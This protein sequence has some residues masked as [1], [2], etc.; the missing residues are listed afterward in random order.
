MAKMKIKSTT[1]LFLVGV[2]LAFAGCSTAYRTGQ[3][4]DDVYSSPAPTQEEYAKIKKTDERRY[5]TYDDA[6][7]EYEDYDD[8][9]LRM[10]VR[11]R[12]RWSDLNDWYYYGD[13]YNFSYYNN[14]AYWNDPWYWN[15][16]WSPVSYWNMWYNPWY[17]GWGW[18]GG[19][20]WGGW[21]GGGWGWNSPWYAGWG[22]WYGGGWGWGGWYDP[23]YNGWYGPGWGW[24]GGWYGGGVI[25]GRRADYG[26]RTNANLGS[27]SGGR[28]NVSVGTG[29]GR[30]TPGYINPTGGT[31]R[32]T[33]GVR[34]N[35]SVST[36]TSN[37][38][39][40]GRS[41]NTGSYNRS[42]NQGQTYNRDVYSAP[43]SNESRPT[44]SPP[45]LHLLILPHLVVV[46]RA[47][48][49]VEAPVVAVAE[50]AEDFS[51]AAYTPDFYYYFKPIKFYT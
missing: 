28:G 42:Y 44:Y 47:V 12:N 24:G 51:T 39:S 11:N 35:A 23:W 29:S 17:S 50:A 15:N 25:V 4:P 8:R 27:Y 7:E 34:S 19:F 5:R 31:Y 43:R 9:Y 38:G 1:L 3:T 41:A 45:P 2:A 48:A 18:G 6:D 32:S 20:G 14:W 13:R 40:Y 10:K 30:T 22:G 49:A 26:P 46:V 21:Y 37:S 33:Y 36:N 16:P